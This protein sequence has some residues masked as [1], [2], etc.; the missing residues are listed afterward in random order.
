[1]KLF[2]QLNF[3]GNCREAFE[4]YQEHLDGKVTMMLDQD[5]MPGPTKPPA[6]IIHA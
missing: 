5:S 3:G 4:F 1:M 6:G 2:V